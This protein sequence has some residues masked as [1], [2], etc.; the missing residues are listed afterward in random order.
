MTVW[1]CASVSVSRMPGFDGRR[2]PSNWGA[3]VGPSQAA[4]PGTDFAAGAPGSRMGPYGNNMAAPGTGNGPY[5]NNMA[6]PGT[7]MGPY[8]NNMAAPGT[9]MGATGSD[10]RTPRGGASAAT[11]LFDF[12]LT[13]NMRTADLDNPNSALSRLITYIVKGAASASQYVAVVPGYS[14]SPELQIQIRD[15][16]IFVP[17]GNSAN[18]QNGFRRTDVLPAINKATALSGVTTFYQTIRLDSR[19]PLVHAHGYLLASIEIPTGDHVWDIFAG[20]DFDSQNTAHTPSRNSQTIRVR[21]L[22][23]NTLFSLPLSYDQAY[24]FAITVDWSANTLTVYASTGNSPLRKVAGPV[25]NDR[26]AASSSG[27]GEYHL[28]LIKFPL[29]D[30]KDPVSKRSDVPHVGF[31]EPIKREHVF[32]SNVYVTS[33]K[34]IQ[35]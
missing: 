35:Q 26:K 25:S 1:L 5:G 2:P 32:F 9:G 19:A 13:P 11:R 20:S 6:A 17:G 22:R 27:Q 31:Q 10:G 7:G 28:Q 4:A 23:T 14:R 21:D 33:G 16:S 29:P 12:R 24:N 34:N 15:D 3:G 8:G 30:A 18:A